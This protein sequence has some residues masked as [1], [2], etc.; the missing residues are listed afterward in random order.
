M[1]FVVVVFAGESLFNDGSAYVLF[2]SYMMTVCV[3]VFYFMLPSTHL[4]HPPPFSA[5]LAKHFATRTWFWGI[6][7][8][9]DFRRIHQSVLGIPLAPALRALGEHQLSTPDPPSLGMGGREST[10]CINFV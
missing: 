6:I 10:L 8:N 5:A 1:F 2:L 4:T 7:Q 3:S 9:R